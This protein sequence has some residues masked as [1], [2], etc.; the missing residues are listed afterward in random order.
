M[1]KPE[2][3]CMDI[4]QPGFHT[5]SPP[6]ASQTCRA[7]GTEAT[8]GRQMVPL[9]LEISHFVNW[10]HAGP[11]CKAKLEQG[12]RNTGFGKQNTVSSTPAMNSY[13]Q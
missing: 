4:I 5:P 8:M 9:F 3:C 6:S 11:R 1:A 12:F 7:G 2:T 10:W 13:K